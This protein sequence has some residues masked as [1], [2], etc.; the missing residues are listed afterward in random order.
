MLVKTQPNKIT[1]TKSQKSIMR[2]INS[3][4]TNVMH[5]K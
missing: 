4:N 1:G 5:E 2:R 3:S